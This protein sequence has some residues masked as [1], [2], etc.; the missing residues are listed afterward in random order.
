M[1]NHGFDTLHGWNEA[2][3]RLAGYG[4]RDRGFVLV[5]GGEDGGIAGMRRFA[6]EVG[7]RLG[8][9]WPR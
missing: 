6:T 1:P 8:R 7:P 3:F 2:E 5:F 4:F 9:A